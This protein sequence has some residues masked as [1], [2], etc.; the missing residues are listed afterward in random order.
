MLLYLSRSN[1]IVLYNCSFF[2][3]SFSF[4]EGICS[5]VALASAVTLISIGATYSAAGIVSSIVAVGTGASYKVERE[6]FFSLA[7][8]TD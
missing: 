2:V 4:Y 7:V 6:E 1:S 5:A 8:N 3:R